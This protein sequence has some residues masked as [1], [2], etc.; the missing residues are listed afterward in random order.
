VNRDYQPCPPSS[1]EKLLEFLKS[2]VLDLARNHPRVTGTDVMA[3]LGGLAA[4]S[5]KIKKLEERHLWERTAAV[6]EDCL[7]KFPDCA[8]AKELLEQFREKF[9]YEFR[10]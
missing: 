10:L 5:S 2:L 8:P 4:G 1:E 7:E 6:T 3:W 9:G